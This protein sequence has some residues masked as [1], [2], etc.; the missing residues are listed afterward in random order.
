M[1]VKLFHPHSQ[2]NTGSKRLK[3]I[4]QDQSTNL[5]LFDLLILFD[6]S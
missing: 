5:I 3:K 4:K 1:L 6:P 2:V